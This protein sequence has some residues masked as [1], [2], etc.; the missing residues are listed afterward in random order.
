M[1]SEH[2]L[3][4]CS[5]AA[6]V[7]DS[8][9]IPSKSNAFLG[10]LCF[11]LAACNPAQPPQTRSEITGTTQERVARATSLLSKY[12]AL[13]GPLLDAHIAEDVHDNSGGRVPGPSDSWLSGVII[14]PAADLGKWR[15][16]LSP[17]IGQTA[18]PAFAGP[19]A[20]PGWW[21]AATAFADCEFYPPR[22]LT[23]HSGGFA[24]LSPSAS[25]IYFSTF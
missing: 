6:T 9:V 17:A 24:A 13:P 20:P 1:S 5:Q 11:A 22:K 25:A 21:P 15:E 7:H 8:P 3:S 2:G 14:V 16:A 19:M 10:L 23:G 12:C 18:S 4:R